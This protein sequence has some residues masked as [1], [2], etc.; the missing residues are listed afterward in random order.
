VYA[1]DYQ[2]RLTAN[3]YPLTADGLYGAAS[4]AATRKLQRAHK[5][6]PDGVVGPQTW[7]A[8]RAL[9]K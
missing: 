4:A 9:P 1:K 3:G 6:T 8:A 5:L 7:A 2:V